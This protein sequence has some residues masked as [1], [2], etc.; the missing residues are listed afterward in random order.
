LDS[1][2]WLLA[3]VTKSVQEIHLDKTVKLLDTPGIVFHGDESSVASVL[4]NCVKVRP[5]APAR[6]AQA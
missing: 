3:G 2:L 1:F 5:P 6:P 4:R